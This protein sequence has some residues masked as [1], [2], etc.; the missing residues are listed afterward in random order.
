MEN[1]R[2]LRITELDDLDWNDRT[3]N[4]STMDSFDRSF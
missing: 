3:F 4:L 1:A 2:F